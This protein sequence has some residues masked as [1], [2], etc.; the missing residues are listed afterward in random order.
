MKK[1]N[2]KQMQNLQ[3]GIAFPK[4]LVV[5]G[6]KLVVQATCN[7]GGNSFFLGNGAAFGQPGNGSSILHLACPQGFFCLFIVF[8][9]LF[10]LDCTGNGAPSVFVFL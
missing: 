10:L 7:Q 4:A 9:A 8:N 1:L 5:N 2:L 6:Q 3:G